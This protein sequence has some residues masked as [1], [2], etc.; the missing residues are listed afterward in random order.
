MLLTV[1]SDGSA[2]FASDINITSRD[3]YV[4]FAA[5]N[6]SELIRA[7]SYA[8]RNDEKQASK[9][10]GLGGEHYFSGHILKRLFAFH[11]NG[12]RCKKYQATTSKS[13]ANY[14]CP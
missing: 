1:L 12:K 14:F 9:M 11:S 2:S 13:T 8:S 4:T 6:Q 3:D 5:V 10:L 7:N